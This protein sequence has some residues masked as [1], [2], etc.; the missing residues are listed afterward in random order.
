MDDQSHQ[1]S[2]LREIKQIMDQSSRFTPVSGWSGIAAGVCAIIGASIA[3]YYLSTPGS[4]FSE[5]D[6]TFIITLI[7]IALITFASAFLLAVY[8]TYK[9]STRLQTTVWSTTAK[10]ALFNVAIPMVVGGI[11]IL[12]LI[13]LQQYSLVT[14]TSLIFYGLAL[15]NGGKYSLAEIKQLGYLQI[16][17]GIA[18][19]WLPQFGLLLWALG[20]GV[21][22][23]IYGVLVLMKYEKKTSEE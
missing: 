6:N 21:L 14:A 1:L 19:C 11:F 23:I 18:N 2:T 9:R 22:H 17:L 7:W 16:L 8:F 15:I 4:A 20:F 13:E 3:Q 10:R 12:K 5:N